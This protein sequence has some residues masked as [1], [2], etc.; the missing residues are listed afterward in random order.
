MPTRADGHVA[1]SDIK[2]LCF[3]ALSF[4]GVLFQ[5]PCTFPMKHMS[6]TLAGARCLFL[7]TSMVGELCLF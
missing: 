4:E 6:L 1:S 3:R 7:A 2:S 5:V